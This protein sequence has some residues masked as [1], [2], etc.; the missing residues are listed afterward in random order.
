MPATILWFRAYAALLALT[1]LG[2]VA[3][4]VVFLALP[5]EQLEMTSAES[6][7]VGWIFILLGLLFT[8]AVLPAFFLPRQGWAWIYGLALMV[9]GL[10]S[11]IF[12]PLCIPLIIFW[13]K[14]PVKDWFVP[15]AS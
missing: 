8:A 10:T 6:V 15:I 14:D 1:Y 2:L 11:V 3:L 9:M 7:L 12:I 13:L 5:P 4:G